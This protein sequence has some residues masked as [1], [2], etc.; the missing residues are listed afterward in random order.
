MAGTHVP[1]FIHSHLLHTWNIYQHWGPLFGFM[2]VNKKIIHSP[3]FFRPHEL[4]SALQAAL[5]GR[6]VFH[7]TCLSLKRWYDRQEVIESSSKV[8]PSARAEDRT[9]SIAE[10]TPNRWGVLSRMMATWHSVCTKLI[11]MLGAVLKKKKCRLFPS[12][13]DDQMD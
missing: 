13:A 5:L 10:K 2:L 12:H 1:I 4:S 8:C 3:D 11:L 6:T 9:V 7:L